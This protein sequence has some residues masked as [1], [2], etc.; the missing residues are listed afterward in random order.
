MIAACKHCGQPFDYW[1][2]GTKGWVSRQ[3]EDI[4]C[5][6]CGEVHGQH[7][8]LGYVRSR[9]LTA[10]EREAYERSKRGPS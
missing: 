4:G 7:V 1:D 6:H 10:E 8:T 9:K 5:P 3:A 2:E